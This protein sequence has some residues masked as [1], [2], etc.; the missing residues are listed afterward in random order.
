M[1]AVIDS[2]T[3]KIRKFIQYMYIDASDYYK[4]EGDLPFKGQAGRRVG[5]EYESGY[6]NKVSRGR[7][8]N[9]NYSHHK[10]RMAS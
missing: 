10:L 1:S 5:L 2:F 6:A 3:P 7:K 9:K 4:K 8:N